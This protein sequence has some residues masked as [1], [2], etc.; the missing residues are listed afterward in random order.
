MDATPGR[1]APCA[2]PDSSGAPEAPPQALRAPGTA[3]VKAA[4]GSRAEA[5][6]GGKERNAVDTT[7]SDAPSGVVTCGALPPRE[8]LRVD[9]ADV[10]FFAAEFGALHAN[11][12]GHC[13]VRTCPP[14]LDSDITNAADITNNVA[15]VERGDV[16]APFAQAPCLLLF[17][18]GCGAGR[19][20]AARQ[21]RTQRTQVTFVEKARRAQAAGACLVAPFS[22]VPPGAQKMKCAVA[23]ASPATPAKAST[24]R[25]HQARSP[26]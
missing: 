19:A 7:T 25:V 15:V 21:R 14:R 23:H 10:E 18:C 17:E 16:S 26:S 11:I 13:A 9:G 4:S 12:E 8:V 3:R 2:D 5:A 20:P 1:A 24:S 6:D 22:D